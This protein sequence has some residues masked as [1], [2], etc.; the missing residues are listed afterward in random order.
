MMKLTYQRQK[1]VEVHVVLKVCKLVMLYHV[2]HHPGCGG[3]ER[4]KPPQ[5]SAELVKS[6]V[7][8]CSEMARVVRKGCT[9]DPL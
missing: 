4:R 6:P 9:P 3:K 1:V 5:K 7:A 8:E 2:L